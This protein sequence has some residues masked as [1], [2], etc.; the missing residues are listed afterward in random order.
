MFYLVQV[1]QQRVLLRRLLKVH[2]LFDP[3]L[4]LLRPHL[5]RRGS[6]ALAQEKFTQPVARPQLIL[7]G[8]FAS[9]HQIPQRLMFFVRYPHRR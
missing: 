3:F 2:L 5:A 1:I 4:I 8:C 6:S 9:P 7:L